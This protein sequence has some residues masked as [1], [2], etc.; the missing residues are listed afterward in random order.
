MTTISLLVSTEQPIPERLFLEQSRTRYP[1][2]GIVEVK[3]P[4][5]S[6]RL[7][8]TALLTSKDRFVPE[9][10]GTLSLT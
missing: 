7:C 10:A 6:V 8:R 3:M 9:L 1:R 5:A 4:L 2:L